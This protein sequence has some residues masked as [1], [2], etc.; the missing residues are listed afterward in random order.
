MKAP[1]GTPLARLIT[2]RPDTLGAAI[3]PYQC[4]IW[5]AR[6]RLA[7]ILG[8]YEAIDKIGGP[9]D[10]DVGEQL[11]VLELNEIQAGLR[12]ILDQPWH[13]MREGQLTLNLVLDDV[14]LY[15]VVFS[16]ILEAGELVAFVGAIQG[17][18]ID[19]VLA[20]YRELTKSAH[21][22]RPR[23]LIVEIF[24]MFCAN[25]GV[26]KIY[27]VSD[28]YRHHKHVYFKSEKPKKSSVNYDEIWSERGGVKEDPTYFRLEVAPRER[29]LSTVASKKREMYRRRYKMLN[30][31][32][33]QMA[34]SYFDLK[35]AS[36][37]V[38]LG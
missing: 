25:I 30:D 32:R 1:A 35:A 7:R 5:D 37:S 24:R 34:A 31:I 28:A 9:I 18:D 17:R 15:S 3:W 12:V 27:A 6:M 11:V 22:M 10:F 2:R 38:S 13:F 16:L 20:S 29:D 36:P 14:R 4:S 33:Q 19:G 21:G 26:T 8:H 23:D